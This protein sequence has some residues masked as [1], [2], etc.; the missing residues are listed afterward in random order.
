MTSHTQETGPM[1]R[2]ANWLLPQLMLSQI[3]TKA[4]FP[5]TIPLFQ[6]A[7]APFVARLSLCSCNLITLTPSQW[8]RTGTRC[9]G[10]LEQGAGDWTSRILDPRE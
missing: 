4:A 3:K 10:L 9:L 2:D 6:K 8:R 5:L 1:P 7:I